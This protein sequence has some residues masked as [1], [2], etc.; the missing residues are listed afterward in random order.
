MKLTKSVLKKIIAE[1]LET[2]QVNEGIENITPE[3]LGIAIDAIMK[4][5]YL[6]LPIL[7]TA[8]VAALIEFMQSKQ[9][10]ESSDDSMLNRDL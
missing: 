3:N 1:E 9:S 5:K 10:G 8:G 4:M 7:G 6:L 2:E